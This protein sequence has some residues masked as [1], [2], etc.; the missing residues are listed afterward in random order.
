MVESSNSD[1]RDPLD[2]S[3]DDLQGIAERL[4]HALEELFAVKAEAEQMQ[5]SAALSEDVQSSLTLARSA[6]EGSSSSQQYVPDRR[7]YVPHSQGWQ[8]GIQTGARTYCS[9]RQPGEDW[10][11]LLVDGEIYLH[12][13][14]DK[15]CLNCA[16][17]QGYITADRL[18]WQTGHRQPPS[19][20]HPADTEPFVAAQSD[21]VV[22]PP[23]SPPADD[24]PTLRFA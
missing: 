23:A 2:D 5:A 1:Q 20:Q 13:G 8:T 15:L 14:S 6:C 19:F 11:H 17:R 21:P 22:I 16:L 4:K 18:Y 24:E 10:F 12:F 9:I 3:A 7:L